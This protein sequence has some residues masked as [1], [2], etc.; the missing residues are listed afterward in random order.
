MAPS[1]QFLLCSIA[2]VAGGIG[3][4][5]YGDRI[6]ELT[7][8]G[9]T[10]IGLVLVASVTSLPELVTGVSAVA[11]ARL[12]DIALGDALGSCAFNLAVLGAADLLRRERGLFEAA[13]KSQ[14]AAGWIGAALLASTAAAIASGGVAI[15]VAGASVD[16]APFVLVGAYVLAMR[17]LFRIEAAAP[18]PRRST[19]E[20]ASTRSL[21]R[22][23]AGYAGASGLVLVA[24]VLLPFVASR[25]AESMR[26][27]ESFVGVLLVA[28]TTSLPEIVVTI[29]AI[30]IGAAELA[31]GNL[32]GSNLFDLAIVGV[33]V[34][35]YADG[36]LLADASRIHALPA[37]AAAAMTATVVFALA[38]PRAAGRRRRWV[39]PIL[40]A[41]FVAQAYA[42]W[43]GQ[44]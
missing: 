44:P 26:W 40:I 23:V 21:R 42:V 27:S 8:L 33:D 15:H 35:L 11:Y 4:S 6:A 41:L 36:S 22:S 39:A 32:L 43:L 2:V 28:M 38:R 10:W 20:R 18:V 7:G 9:R 24:G 34:A 29:A 14:I 12:P 1:I 19:A 13:R 31:V 30:R 37:A 25:L 17:W 3:I 16:P 5:H